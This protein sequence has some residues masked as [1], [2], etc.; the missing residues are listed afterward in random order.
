M[1]TGIDIGIIIIYLLLTIG[2]GLYMARRAKGSL[3]DYFLGGRTIPWYILGITGMATYIDVSGTMVQTS[4]F[5]MFG[6]KGY[7]VAFRGAMALFLA[8]LMVFMGKWLNRSGVMTNAEWMEFRFGSDKQGQTARLLSALSILILIIAFTAYFFIGTG[9]FFSAYLPF[10]PEI[11][12]LLFYGIVTIYTVAA[13]FYG[14]VYTDV[15]QAVLIGGMI[16]FFTVKAMIVGTPEYFHAFTI[17]E[18]HTLTPSWTMQ[19]PAGYE[20]MH[21]FGL[22]IIFWIIT[23]VFQG[24]ALPFDAWTS[25]RY[26]AAKNERESS[27]VAAQWIVLFSLR[28]LLM[29]G[30][31]ILAMG[32][33]GKIG[34]PEMAFTAV[35]EHY[36]PPI[37][38]GLILA[39]LLAAAMSTLSSF[40]NA[41]AAYYVK[42]IYQRHIKKNASN[43]HLINA[44]Y[45]S[46][47]A[48]IV[49]GVI[50]GWKMPTINY[51][52]A[53]IIMGLFTGMM[54][55]NIIKWFW[56]RF[57]GMGYAYGMGS[58]MLAAILQQ[59]FFPNLPEYSIFI[60]VVVVSTIGTIIGVYAGK[61]TDKD[62]LL[63]FYKKTRPFGFWGPV[64]K[65]CDSA[66]LLEIDKENHRDLLLLLPACLW[67]VTLFWL[68]T[69]FVAKKWQSVGISLVIIA[70]L[71]YLL[72]CYWYKGL[73]KEHPIE[74]TS[75]H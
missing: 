64:R 21:L 22:L 10:R 7:W 24:F 51:I 40:V 31:G 32:I 55:P 58:G 11:N 28:F 75:R 33:A 9:K 3:N 20:S 43:R 8:F 45:V 61:P 70:A 4:F 27:L 1:L 50:V 53:W 48:I 26:Y 72:Y 49:L 73:K 19:M 66:L 29:M 57:N 18:W 34:D 5:Y 68:M 36:V 65:E 74:S 12:G 63:N 25:Q 14:V 35:I 69:A 16:L 67:Q 44:S 41:S 62:V 42:D 2:I 59:A 39:A 38:K 56:W 71:S 15:F 37:A 13:G 30:V 54:P 17:Q 46:T 47:V 23:N 60:F 52:W 6:V